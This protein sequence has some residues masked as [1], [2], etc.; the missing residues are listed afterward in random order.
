MRQSWLNSVGITVA[1]AVPGIKEADFTNGRAFTHGGNHFA[2]PLDIERT[3]DDD[4]QI[5]L[6]IALGDEWG[7][8]MRGDKFPVRTQKITIVRF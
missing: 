6:R 3:A 7:I 5:V 8:G 1:V 2:V 4:V